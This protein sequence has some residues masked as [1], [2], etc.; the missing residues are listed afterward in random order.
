MKQ[1]CKKLTNVQI[2]DIMMRTARDVTQGNCHTRTGGHA[3]TTGPDLATGNGLVDAHKAVLVAKIRC[4][5]IIRGPIRGSFREREP[6]RGRIEPIREREPVMRGRE[7]IIEPIRE[8]EPVRGGIEPPIRERE[9]IRPSIL[10]ETSLEMAEGKGKLTPEDIQTLE[11]M[12]I[13]SELDEI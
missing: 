7:P 12:V 3:A 1:A 2:R 11:D 13:D 6:V 8:R 10:E 9:P 4:I 5:G